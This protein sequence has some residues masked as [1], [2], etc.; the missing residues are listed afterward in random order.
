M[1]CPGTGPAPGLPTPLPLLSSGAPA[2]AWPGKHCSPLGQDSWVSAV[3]RS[4]R[5]NAVSQG[6]QSLVN[7]PSHCRCRTHPQAGGTEPGSK[8]APTFRSGML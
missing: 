5:A 3:S 1:L 8:A 7:P 2:H 4:S 6:E